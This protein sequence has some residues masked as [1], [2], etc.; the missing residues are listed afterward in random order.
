[1]K[2]LSLR[3]VHAMSM[4]GSTASQAV[5]RLWFSGEHFSRLQLKHCFYMAIDFLFQELPIP[6]N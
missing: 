6:W 4:L 5:R 3:F 1:M 2:V